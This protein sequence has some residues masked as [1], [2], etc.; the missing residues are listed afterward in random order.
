MGTDEVL[1]AV[2]DAKKGRLSMQEGATDVLESLG[3]SEAFSQLGEAIGD[4]ASVEDVFRTIP[5]NTGGLFKL[6][7]MLENGGALIRENG[8]S[9]STIA[10]ALKKS[11][12]TLEQEGSTPE[13][14]DAST[15]RSSESASSSSRKKTAS[16]PVGMDLNEEIAAAHAERMGQDFYSFLGISPASPRK[17]V[18]K[19][20]KGLAQK[21][22]AA[23]SSAGLTAESRKILKDLLAGVQLVWRTLTDP[24]HKREYD[25]RLDMGRAPKVEI[26]VSRGSAKL[27]P[28]T[29][30]MSSSKR[31]AEPNPPVGSQ[32]PGE[33]GRELINKGQF[34]EAA[35]ILEAARVENPSDPSILADLGWARW[36]ARIWGQE[37]DAPEEFLRLALTFEPQNVRAL[38]FMARIAIDKGE[39][40]K[41]QKIL[42]RILKITPSSDWARSALLSLQK[43]QRSETVTRK[44]GFWRDKGDK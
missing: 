9:E 43:G 40:E 24:K 7:W 32:G 27:P 1:P 39:K 41:A 12:H 44:R 36:K 8:S 30:K 15:A 26:R 25:R 3:L 42:K 14:V 23:D 2:T 4:G 20:C 17:D 33:K 37:E 19:A 22:R 35:N 5:D 34:K 11:V 16:D 31:K 18:D 6:I 10:E 13:P 29:S 28:K 38:E 21:W